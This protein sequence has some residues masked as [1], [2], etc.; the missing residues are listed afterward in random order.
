M[1]FLWFLWFMNF[2]GRT[3]FSPILPLIEDEFGV[4]HAKAAS[5]FTFISFGYAGALF[6]SGMVN[7]LLGAKRTILVSL[8]IAAC[9]FF[10]IPTIHTFNVFYPVAFVMAFALGVY[11]PTIIPMITEYY[12]PGLWGKTIAIHESATAFS[13]FA[14]P[15]IALFLL[16]FLPWRGIFIVTGIIALASAL[17]FQLVADD[18][19]QGD[20]AR[21][22]RLSLLARREVWIMGAIWVFCSGCVLGLYFVLPLYLVKE[23]GMDVRYANSIFGLSRL[24]MV[25]V[26]IAAGFL[27][28]RVN[29]KKTLFLIV[30]ITGVLTMFLA[31]KDIGLIKPLLFIQATI[32]GGFPSLAL[33][34]ISRMFDHETRG[35]ATGF[36]ITLGMLGSGVI[37]HLIGFTGDLV[38]FRL[39]IFLLGFCTTVTS[40]LIYFL[41][42]G[43]ETP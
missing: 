20:G 24:G 25:V 43:R 22:F 29:V 31:V 37:P 42:K 10:I 35:Q 16:A 14:A 38:S 6:F 1:L 17:V 21:T 26:A 11:L 40:G 32:S 13:I 34:A 36:V 33:V 2:N 41:K 7:G 12:A 5:I 9:S 8:V 3:L 28:D 27:V 4:A 39:G 30:L 15:F 19:R 23:L 18:V